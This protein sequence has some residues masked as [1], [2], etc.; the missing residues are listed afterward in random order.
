M[1]TAWDPLKAE[2]NYRKHGVRFSDA[3]AVPY[4]PASII[5]DENDGDGELRLV[6]VGV[7]A[8]GRVV[9]VVLTWRE[10]TMRLISARRASG[11]ERKLYEEGI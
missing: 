4:D 10:Q 8:V 2:A 1:T 3:Q 6:M 7:D 5:L 11:P 9:V